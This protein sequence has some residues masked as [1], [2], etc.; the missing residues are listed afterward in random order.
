MSGNAPLAVNFDA[1]A[2][3]EPAGACGTINSYTLDFGDGSA[4]VTQDGAHPM[5]SHNYPNPG[6]YPARLAVGDTA[7]LTSINPAQIIITVNSAASPQLSAVDSVMTHGTAGT[8]PVHLPLTGSPGIEC[9][10]GG[11]NGNYKMVF[12]F[13]NPLSSVD[14]A[15]ITA[16]AG[17][18]SSAGIGTD[19]HQYIVNLTGVANAQRVTVALV[20]AHDS[21]NA[22]GNVSA[23]MAVLIGDTTA[24]GHVNSTDISQTQSQSG[25]P[26]TSDNF[27]MDVTVNGLIN[28]SDIS[29]VQQQSGTALP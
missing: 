9:R 6:A 23:T 8:F 13:A 12:T 3:N 14:Q 15:T 19:T 27:R 28:S 17:S 4:P 26:V 2:S 11:P 18:V 16:G 5:F 20:N 1:S 25:Q 21:T 7:G 10:S 24:N 22:I 29:A